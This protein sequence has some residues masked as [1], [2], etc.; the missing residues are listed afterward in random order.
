MNEDT[1]SVT[2]VTLYSVTAVIT[3]L[4]NIGKVLL[5][6]SSSLNDAISFPV[7]SKFISDSSTST[8][9]L[10]VDPTNSTL[11]VSLY[12]SNSNS[13]IVVV[14]KRL[15]TIEEGTPLQ[16]QLNTIVLHRNNNYDSF[17]SYLHYALSPL[18]VENEPDAVTT[19]TT[20]LTVAKKKIAE[21]ELSFLHLQQNIEIPTVFLLPDPIIQSL[22][23]SSSTIDIHESQ[24]N[25]TQLKQLSDTV[26]QW[27][28]EIQKVTKL[29]REMSTSS[30]SLEINF[31]LSLERALVQIEEQL[32]E[33]HVLKTLEILKTAKRFQSTVSFHTDT[34]LK[35]KIETVQRYNQLMKDFPLNELLSATDMTK[36]KE[37]LVLIFGHLNKKLKL[38]P[39]PIKRA[40]MLV[41]SI[42]RDMTDQIVKVLSASRLMHLDYSSFLR[43]TNGCEEVFN[44]WEEQ[45]KD[46]SSIAREVLKKR[47]EKQLI[48]TKVGTSHK[49][50]QERINFIR[51]FR[52]QHWNL[53]Q[54][55]V[56]VMKSEKL[57]G[58]DEIVTIEEINDAY[59]SV[60]GID[61]LDVTDEGT[62]A[63]LSSEAL[64]NQ[65]V[66]RVENQIIQT[67]RG[68]LGACKTANEMFRSFS[69]FN[70]LFVRPKIRGAIHEYQSQLIES[71]K[72]D[73]K[74]LVS[75]F[76]EGYAQSNTNSMS[77][78]RD[79]PP[80]SAQIV[81]V[82]QLD[83]QL[84]L[85]MKR[86][87]DVLGSGWQTYTDGQKLQ[88]E[89]ENFKK[90]LETKII[91]D[92][93]V[94][95]I[96]QRDLSFNGRI[97]EVTKS[98][99]R[100]KPQVPVLTLRV[101]FDNVL[102]SGLFKEVRNLK[103]LNFNIP[104]PINIQTKNARKVYPFA[105]S[106]MESLKTWQKTCELVEDFKDIKVLVEGAK[107][108]VQSRISKHVLLKWESFPAAYDVRTTSFS[109]KKE[110][111][112]HISFV[113]DFAS[114]VASFQEKVLIALDTYDEIARKIED[115]RDCDFAKENF[116]QIVRQIQ[117]LIDDK[118]GLN[119]SNL[120]HWT[121]Y[122]D[123]KIEAV[124]INRLERAIKIWMTEFNGTD[125]K[126]TVTLAR[127]RRAPTPLL[128][129]RVDKS[130]KKESKG[131][132]GELLQKGDLKP[133]LKPLVHEISIRDKVLFVNPPVEFARSQ[134][135]VMLQDW[136]AVICNLPKIKGSKFEHNLQTGKVERDLTYANLLTKLSNH[137]L[138]SAYDM[139]NTKVIQVSQ[140]I[141]EWLEYQSL[142][143]LTFQ[144][145]S[146]RLGD[147]L[148]LWQQLVLDIKRARVTFDNNETFKSLG[149]IIID[150]TQVQ[151]K[152]NQ[153][154]DQWQSETVRTFG[155]RLNGAMREF[156][157]LL[158]NSREKL[159]KALD[160]SSTSSAVGFITYVQ[161]LKRKEVGWSKEVEQFRNGQKCL[162][163]MRY[164]FGGDWLDAGQID[165]EWAAFGQI[166][167]RK[168]DII[169]EQ[170]GGLQNKIIQE[171]KIISQKIGEF[172]TEWEAEKPQSGSIPPADATQKLQIFSFQLN[173]LQNEFSQVSQAKEAL[174][175]AI[176]YDNRLEPIQEELEGFKNV[177]AELMTY[178]NQ[179]NELKEL[180]FNSASPRKI[181]A[182]LD[183]L[184]LA[185][186][187]MKPEMRTYAA[188]EYMQDTLK[189]HVKVNPI[190]AELKSEALQ[191][192]HWQRLFKVLKLERIGLNELTVGMVWDCGLKKVEE[193]VREIVVDAQGE[194]A[195]DQFLASIQ[196][197]WDTYVFDLIMYQNKVRL[198]RGWDELFTKCR[199]HLSSISAMKHSPYFKVF[200][201]RATSW[202]DKLNRL[203]LLLDVW[204]EVQRQWVYLEGIFT[205]N[206]DIKNL[207][208]QETNRFNSINTDFLTVMQRVSKS[209][210]V[211]EIL[212][213]PDIQ[214]KM[215]DLT[216]KLT[217]I[218]RALG[219][220]L[221]RER[222][223]FPRFYFVGDEDLLEIIGNSKDITRIQKHFKKMFSGVA[224][225]IMSENGELIDGI[226]S[227]EG[228]RVLFKNVVSVK[229]NPRINDW[230][231]LLE[232]EIKITLSGLLQDA[233]EALEAFYEELRIEVLL[234]WMEKFPAQL[235]VVASQIMWTKL[236][237]KGLSKG[238]ANAMGACLA[239][240]EHGLTVLADMV[241]SELTAIQRKKCE[242]LITELV[243]ERDVIRQLIKKK[244]NS[245][246]DFTWLYQMRFYLVTDEDPLLR[247]QIHMANA[248]F[249]YGFEY[250]GVPERLVQTPLTDRCYLTMTQALENKLGGSPFGPA[251]TG[252]TESVKS[253]GVQ[254][255]RFVLV[256]CC[257]ENFDFQAMGR[258]F[259]GLC[260][261][262]AYGCFDEFNR[263][264]EAILSAVSQQIQTIQLGLKNRSEIELVG[265]NLT[266]NRNTGIFITMNPGYAGRS[267]LPDNL[268]K[269]FR[270]IAMTK[271]DRELIA[272]VMLYTQGFRTAELLASK[273]VPLFN[274]CAEQ[275]SPQS[276]YDFGL[277][278]LKSVL[279]SA[280]NLKR[281][282][283][284]LMNNKVADS[285]Q[286]DATNISDENTEQQILIQSIRETVAPK[287]VVDDMYLLQ[288]LLMDVF[289]GVDYNPASLDKLKS[290]ILSVCQSMKM[291]NTEFWME[292]IIQLYQIQ[293]IH[294]GL[295]MVG[296]SGSGK[297]VAWRVLLK[298]LEEMEGVEGVSYVIDP[299]SMSKENLYGS[300]DATTR[301]WTDGL[302]TSILRKI[303]DNVR[304]ENNKRHW[305]IFDGDVDPAWVENL[306]SVLDD[307][308]LLTLPNGER[309]G[310]P[311]N[312]RIM[313]EVDTLKYATLATVSRCGMV[314]FSSE[315]VTIQMMFSN[316]L[317]TLR[318]VAMD[319]IEEELSVRGNNRSLS[320]LSKGRIELSAT[321]NE[322]NVSTT[323]KSQRMAV[324]II[325][326]FFKEEGLVMKALEYAEG[327][328]HIMDF[329]V[330]RALTTLFS[331][332]N[333]SI[334]AI[335]DYNNTHDFPLSEDVV[336]NFISK[337]LLLA[338]VWSFSG[339]SRLE[340]RTQLGE[341]IQS[342]ATVELPEISGSDSLLDF[343]V[344]LATQNWVNWAR[345]VPKIEIEV[346]RVAS[347]DLVIPTMDTV[348]HE[349]ILYSWLSEH[350]PLI[351]CGPPG[352]GKT[353]TLF[354]ALRK[355]PDLEVV[356]LNFSSATTPELILKTFEQYCEY[357]KTPDGVV[358][359][360]QVLNKWL[361]LFC[362]EINLPMTD[363]YGTQRVISFLRSLVE[364]GGFWRAADKAWIRLERIQFVGAC[365]PPTD[366]GRVPMTHRFLRHAPLVMV[367]YPG[368]VSLK[369][370][371][372]T[373]SRAM[374]QVVPNLRG[375]SEALTAAMVEFYLLS[376]RRFTPDIQAH[377]V[378]SPREL[379]RWVRGIFEA[380]R[381]LDN[382]SLEGLIRVWAH[383]GLRLFQD[384]LVTEDER[385]WTD[386]N[387]DAVAYKHF[388]SV[389]NTDALMR[390]ILFSNWTSKYYI[391]VER[392]VLR[393]F[394]KERLKVFYEEELDSPLVLFNDVLD[395]VLR[396]DRVFRQ[397][398]GHM[399]L[400]GVSGSGKTTLS[401]FVAWMN[402][403]SVFQIKAHNNYKASDFDDDLRTVLR[404]AGCKGEKI[405]FILDESNVLDSGF[406]ERMNTLL[407]NAEVP[408]LFDGDEF[409][410]LMTQ[411]K[412]GAQREG[413][414]LDSQDELYKWFTQQVMKNLHIV[415]TMNP[416]QNGLATRAAT[417]PA[418][419]NRCVLDWFGD[420]SEQGFY[421]VGQEFTQ[422]L[423]LDNPSYNPPS[424]F[425]IAYRGLTLP[426]TYRNAVINA[427]VHVHQSVFDVNAKVAKRQERQ[428][429]IT[430]RH[431]L[432]FISHYQRLF[433]QKRESL[434]EQQ[435]HLI[436]GL[437][438]LHE[439][440][441]KVE[442]LRASLNL[443]SAKIDQKK[444]E[445]QEKMEKMVKDQNVANAKKDASLILKSKI[446]QKTVEIEQR[447]AIVEDELALAEPAVI[448]AQ[449]SVKEIKK[450]QLTEVRSMGNPP[451]LVKMAMESVCAMLGHTIDSWK[452]VQTVI[453]RD[454]FIASIVGYETEKMN[455]KVRDEVRARYL[456]DPT[457]SYE[458]VNR[459]SKACG[460]LVLWVTAQIRYSEIIEKIGPLREE[461][462]QLEEDANKS[463][464]EAKQLDVMIAE[465]DERVAQYEEEYGTLMAEREE[466]KREMDKTVERVR[467]SESLINN[468]SSEK[469]RWQSTSESF[470]IQ[471]GTIIGD[472]LLSSAF[473]AY[474]GYFDQVH[475]E[476]LLQNWMTHMDKAK[477]L[478]KQDLSLTEY[479]STA[480]ER[481]DW[482]KKSLPSDD[483]CTENAIML[484]RYIRY[485]LIIDP[486]GQAMTFLV[487]EFS[488]SG[489]KLTVTSFLDNSF[490]KVLESA[491]RFG[492]PLLVQD[493]E[494]L[495]PILNAVLNKELRKTGGRTLIRLGGQEIDFSPN[496]S[497]FLLTRDPTVQFA[498]DICS[499]VTFV[500]FTITRS[501]LQ[502]QCLHSVLKAER[503]DT[504]NK[505]MDMLKLQ[506]EFQITLRRLE[507]SLLQSL[508]ES[509][510][511]IL[512]DLNVIATL[513]KLKTEAEEV[514][515]K[516]KT[517]DA[518]MVEIEEVTTLYTPLAMSCSS[519]FFV[520]EQ[521]GLLHHFYQFSLSFFLQIFEYVLHNNP[522]LV[523]KKDYAERLSVLSND[524]FS[525]TY[526]R[527]VRSLL[528]DDHI[529][530]ALLLA[531]IKTRG[532][533]DTI[534]DKE[535]DF[536]LTGGD[537][538]A[539]GTQAPRELV[540]ILGE[541]AALKVISL[542]K[543]PV[544]N[545]IV[546]SILQ[547]AQS[548]S[549]VANSSNP[550]HSIPKCWVSPFDEGKAVKLFRNMVVIKCI[551]P[552]RLLAAATSF[553]EEVFPASASELN[554]KSLVLDETS[555]KT[556]I[557]FCSIPGYD[558]S[559]RVENFAADVG[560]RL[561]SV[562]MGS[563][564]GT[565]L[566]L[567]GIMKSSENGGY[568]LL[569]NVHLAPQWLSTLEKKLHGMKAHKDFRLFLTMET[570]PNVPVN[571]LRQSR[572]LL[573]EPPPGIKANLSET[574]SSVPS[575]LSSK[576]PNERA[577]LYFLLAWLHALVLERLRY[578]PMGW[579]KVY[580]FNDSDHDMGLITIDHWI[581]RVAQG[582]SNVSPDKI[583]W[584]AIKT[585][586]KETIYGGKIDNDMDQLLLNSFIDKLFNPA[587][588]EINFSLIE[589]KISELCI[590]DAN[591]LSQFIDWTENL[592]ERQPPSWL[593]LPDNAEK[594][595]LAVKG[596]E[597]LAKVTKMRS[598]N[599][600]EE[601]AYTADESKKDTEITQP[602]W[603]RTLLQF[604]N[605]C[606]SM[607]PESISKF[608]IDHSKND[609]LARYF[610]RESQIGRNLLKTIRSD[611]VD[612]KRVCSG[613]I[614]Q[615][616]HLRSLMEFL[617]KGIVPSHWVKYTIPDNTTVHKWI[618]DF[619]Q[620]LEQVDAIV[621][622]KDFRSNTIWIGGL[623]IPEA[624]VTAT[625]QSIA[626]AN[627]WSLEELRLKVVLDAKSIDG[628][629]IAGLKLE[630]AKISGNLLELSDSQLNNKLPD[631]KLTWVRN[632]TV[633]EDLVKVPVY[634]NRDRKQFLFSAEF[635]ADKAN[636]NFIIQRGVAVVISSF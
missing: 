170:M 67:L 589:S 107:A 259:I 76:G 162:K 130:E 215:E 144:D 379:T 463:K 554:L 544:F 36:I 5:D 487:N 569:K 550:E 89:C 287:L 3:Y 392:Q 355:L 57:G 439:T 283:L 413:S 492:N 268:K 308:K 622:R 329:T 557:A 632:E 80:V 103:F 360:P 381:P 460:P 191:Q 502:S 87:E 230:L 461:M 218:Q 296:P 575:A 489:R 598:L 152:V 345:R 389:E 96:S 445:A 311:P 284:S 603:M 251:G 225:I 397:M 452:S 100:S 269:L 503:P 145:V 526:Q 551:R 239:L 326:K 122:V 223:T 303:V 249:L 563:D 29:D 591:R 334:R 187:A 260:R 560:V 368:E 279:V 154:Y 581:D 525:V 23:A 7:V 19:G 193:K 273:I 291:V 290:H 520:L 490:L 133:E 51:G 208:P 588:F 547:N 456:N 241:L 549:S 480:D 229:M 62:E 494:F 297:S 438:K 631:L 586:L 183:E 42:C 18:L 363:K 121:A 300:L 573:F 270:S 596:T 265:K 627:K 301:E 20:G 50:I 403:L 266:V 261:V 469:E 424:N 512:E 150:Y 15:G 258:I 539:H 447:K 35:A 85:Y 292:K 611:L 319:S 110:T 6:S 293:N 274:L 342:L 485:P 488:G 451:A 147:D 407:A 570:N 124:L 612:L 398:Q 574:L 509:Q 81:W 318:H 517:T 163:L 545:G 400:I 178:W 444:A 276:H 190:L 242:D 245:P 149:P 608:S 263:L 155:S 534:D 244:A 426:P 118:L 52:K 408:G 359:S 553:T 33:K 619:Q 324:M 548:W 579:T 38:T 307:N 380:I 450:Q 299:K 323:L 394:V 16:S 209:P 518:V 372:G 540:N 177:W 47:P 240:I 169:T 556:P 479:L 628:F 590:P 102:F 168:S 396:I 195:L 304:G 135:Y 433:I 254:L 633:N 543:L 462:R 577:R 136:L 34:G 346:Q 541:E 88:I 434:E 238:D 321:D 564:E 409:S 440:V 537:T 468:L 305:I 48:M 458:M 317:E 453:R 205:G 482:Q 465:L 106:L 506:G 220:Y 66:A 248:V 527:A 335:V 315:V 519:I 528:H 247:L 13:S 420:W 532:T 105:V 486:S 385:K 92:A 125:D 138:E 472:V 470:S 478:Y 298:A 578:A 415:F 267:N 166:L 257:D 104:H 508:N 457:F 621:K 404:R 70:S 84:D 443:Q 82:R 371:Y 605:E 555:N 134:F 587:S 78:L 192:R 143:D 374:L 314:W 624:F 77:A 559:Y 217:K 54:T 73:I 477:I 99:S 636:V 158:K 79:L 234:D 28:L 328:E 522:H 454:D 141:N 366:P 484:K 91:F 2:S 419:F 481:L 95:R 173:K 358:L 224:N 128:D 425:P 414:M 535:Y 65:K 411:C 473:I 593:G 231:L 378:Y 132:G 243:H 353:M 339:D 430:P 418:L 232:K 196:E 117:F 616:N 327:L 165:G 325:E 219:D 294:H 565:K 585:L 618:A 74:K 530:L 114:D 421:Q 338:V 164:S 200:Q 607:L 330:M 26:K 375:Y 175:L 341:L 370:I 286:T 387:L 384:R 491:L 533:V 626:Q 623:F 58:F 237:E 4:D 529:T 364:H 507:K 31:W 583:P 580:E 262:G 202:E 497:L 422:T 226:E 332:L 417:S 606:L 37:S 86:V 55:I 576:G 352:S 562:A 30:A 516:M 108:E 72:L 395:H 221:E 228:E 571:L 524:V 483:L 505:R 280:G 69:K 137:T 119:Y 113:R 278:S 441:A 46:F 464:L 98:L 275:L 351:L 617:N 157:D 172:V 629:T 336:E 289:P 189:S 250:L 68:K 14:I 542:S 9:Y 252:K 602:L 568:V 442:E 610:Y 455:P 466:L 313:F 120:D 343:D 159:E 399:L 71:V 449:S 316:Y 459:A 613:Q 161:E 405:C 222:S 350:R 567:D 53:H 373:F 592:P 101:R 635:E 211:I 61:V 493:V 94:A 436:S 504:D 599:D 281:D 24:F 127:G 181:R 513:E 391:P 182:K 282:K 153:R 594:V 416:P 206:A 523:G 510:G 402:G 203:H 39:Y 146:E 109:D 227:K 198:I 383:E 584:D 126:K 212:R 277:R 11:N 171:D 309:L 546:D 435:R 310:L 429:H 213:L 21:L 474:A 467:R 174:D 495:D 207:L 476:S 59:E 386:T 43:A 194:M 538:I 531:Q 401:R 600:D 349:E 216:Q 256:F 446:A 361:V 204:V 111:S 41:D 390:P 496:F 406:L 214:K 272:Q 140:Y 210:L 255:G 558:A 410:T 235:V 184:I 44:T 285:T 471:M 362:D 630:G 176:G 302:F 188:V 354:S 437:D 595:L 312:V 344:D 367:D 199:E 64:Y 340:L 347:A 45:V 615:T 60:K 620:R 521:M 264:S 498:P 348:R 90:K 501:S 17:Y 180:N 160:L 625:R 201:D 93:W 32:K 322:E 572:V 561:T 56:K 601:S 295:M 365:N 40:V 511:N 22:L 337:K 186:R 83:R 253:L 49:S 428:T 25:D 377:Y 432:D 552:D 357:K 63:W 148:A 356:G 412:E 179:I 246:K 131:E 151:S 115:L 536:F 167:K 271:P 1:S 112:V 499:R 233:V 431:Y 393:S 320:G 306:N 369:Q 8:A 597:M 376:Q 116:A 139:I 448:E 566:A 427:F 331:L 123:Q 514:T 27:T 382:L 129:D 423:D 288:S 388:P 604:A 634:L 142:W 75:K 156:Y 12:P 500:N 515:E 10:S 582:R 197:C 97:F 236:V 614:K 185:S 475:R 609:P 333:K